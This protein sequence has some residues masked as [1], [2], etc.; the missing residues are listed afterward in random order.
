VKK[1]CLY[2]IGGMVASFL[3]VWFMWD[4]I[5]N[6]MTPWGK[7]DPSDPEGG[8]TKFMM[9]LFPFVVIFSAIFVGQTVGW[10]IYGIYSFFYFL[11]HSWVKKVENKKN[12]E[13]YNKTNL[14]SRH[15]Y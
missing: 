9:T 1:F 4:I 5:P 10:V 11:A 14:P 13:S 12:E 6:G 2:F 3:Y 8:V 7:L 15:G